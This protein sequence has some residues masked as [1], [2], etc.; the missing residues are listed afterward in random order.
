[1]FGSGLLPFELAFGF[2][3]VSQ[4]F[5]CFHFVLTTTFGSGPLPFELALAHVDPHVLTVTNDDILS[6]LR[7]TASEMGQ[8]VEPTGAV[9]LAAL[10]S[11][12]FQG[13]IRDSHAA[14]AGDSA[15]TG[16]TGVTARSAPAS[17]AAGAGAGLRP[18][19]SVGVVVCGGNVD[20]ARWGG[21]VGLAV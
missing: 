20:L 8:V 2:S 7:L 15:G 9:G 4:H 13:I 11:P 3:H 19:R 5:L 12:A 1:M 21:L 16:I 14:L 6:A 18:I 17:V 10:L